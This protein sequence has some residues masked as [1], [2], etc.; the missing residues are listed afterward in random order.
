MEQILNYQGVHCVVQKPLGD[1]VRIT[2]IDFDLNWTVDLDQ[3][4]YEDLVKASKCPF[5]FE[6]TPAVEPE[7]DSAEA[8][9]E[10]FRQTV[11]S[12]MLRYWYAGLRDGAFRSAVRFEFPTLDLAD[13]NSCAD[14]AWYFICVK[15]A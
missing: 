5:R 2:P 14:C 13:Y 12:A 6:P 8:Q 7:D 15:A 9:Y 11:T 1:G 4:A 10:A 3:A